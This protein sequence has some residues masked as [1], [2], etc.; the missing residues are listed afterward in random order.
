MTNT[1]RIQT[2]A[3]R[4][5]NNVN[6]T[7]HAGDLMGIFWSDEVEDRGTTLESVLDVAFAARPPGSDQERARLVRNSAREV[8]PQAQ[9]KVVPLVIALG[10]V[11]VLLGAGIWTDAAGLKGSSRAVFGLATTAFGI[12]V[13]LLG[14]E[15]PAKSK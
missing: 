9:L 11:G 14:G 7:V 2:C 6:T 4:R 1:E 12:V 15:K 10:I 5:P 13:G 3:P 8:A